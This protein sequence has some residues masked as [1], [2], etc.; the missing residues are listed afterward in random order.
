MS[1]PKCADRLWKPHIFLLNGGMFSSH[2]EILCWFPEPLIFRYSQSC[3]QTTQWHY[4]Y[5]Q[6]I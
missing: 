4:W 5:G 3:Y 2:P 6:K 1:A